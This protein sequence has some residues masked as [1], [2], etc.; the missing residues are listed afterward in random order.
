MNMMLYTMSP[1]EVC[2]KREPISP[3]TEYGASPKHL[4]KN[5]NGL[6]TVKV[7]ESVSPVTEYGASPKHL[8]KNKNGLKTVKVSAETVVILLHEKPGPFWR[9]F[10]LKRCVIGHSMWT[11]ERNM[12]IRAA[13]VQMQL[14]FHFSFLP[15]FDLDLSCAGLPF[16]FFSN[17]TNASLIYRDLFMHVVGRCY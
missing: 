17:Q 7:S 9:V 15:F 16:F 8:M 1:T 5:K 3:V 10:V 14:N 2:S 13:R 12:G 6:K 11:A 4:T